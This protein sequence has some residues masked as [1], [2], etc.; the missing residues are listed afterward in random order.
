MVRTREQFSF[1]FAL[2]GLEC[3][4]RAS[5]HRE[6][7]PSTGAGDGVNQMISARDI[8]HRHRGNSVD[9]IRQIY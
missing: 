6:G 8:H 3:G 2:E 1:K 7:V 4:C 5:V 9:F